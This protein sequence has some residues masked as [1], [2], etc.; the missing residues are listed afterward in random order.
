VR[1]KLMPRGISRFTLPRGPQRAT[2]ALWSLGALLAAGTGVLSLVH[3]MWLFASVYGTVAVGLVLLAVATSRGSRPA[4]LVSLVGLGSQIAG[5]LGA[6]WE[7]HRPHLDSAKAGHLRDL[8]VSYRWAMF[9]NLV[10]SLL[11]GAVF[12]WALVGI[13]NRHRQE[14]G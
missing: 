2:T 7:L 13:G 11:A 14:R 9:S 10:F 3:T 6:G 5:A 4:H 1:R 8:G 12:I